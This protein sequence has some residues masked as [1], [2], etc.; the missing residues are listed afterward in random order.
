MSLRLLTLQ[1][2]SI[3]GVLLGCSKEVSPEGRAL[4]ES[5]ARCAAVYGVLAQNT[6]SQEYRQHFSSMLKTQTQMGFKVI[7]DTNLFRAQFEIEANKL[8]LE[9]GAH[10]GP[11]KGAD[12]LLSQAEKCVEVSFQHSKYFGIG[13]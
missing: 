10:G 7:P 11:Q 4:F 3:C 9:L 8:N 6:S 5:H 13:N 12:Y 2:A 1:L